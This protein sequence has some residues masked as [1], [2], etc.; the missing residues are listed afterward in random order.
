VTTS[1][2]IRFEGPSAMA[3]QVA[4]DLAAADGVDLTSSTPPVP[5]DDATFAL[6][7]TVDGTLEAVTRAVDDLRERLPADGSITVVDG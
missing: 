7:V 6:E 2:R 3:L 5:L 1:Y 4:T